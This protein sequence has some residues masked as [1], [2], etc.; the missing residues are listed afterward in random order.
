MRTV[1]KNHQSGFTLVELAIVLVIIGL[2]LGGVLKG[3]EMIENGKIKNVKNDVEGIPVAYYAYR[4]RY[5]ALPGDDDKAAARWPS[6]APVPTNGNA[7]GLIGTAAVWADCTSAS[8]S[9]NC[10]FMQELRLAGLITGAATPQ[11]P[12]NAYGGVIR[13]FY[14][15]T[16]ANTGAPLGLSVCFGSLPAKAA[17]SIDANFDDGIPTTGNVRAVGGTTAN[18][19]PGTAGIASY[20][21]NTS[22]TSYTVCK[23]L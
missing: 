2:L 10:E 5:S 21:D 20:I 22:N 3:Q 15:T 17:E 18:V 13:V 9:E 4:D 23:L 14:N 16:A 11:D 1:N 12:L 19:T 8:T 6:A 7:N